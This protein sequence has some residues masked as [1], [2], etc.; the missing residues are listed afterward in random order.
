MRSPNGTPLSVP[1]SLK[2]S[3]Y[4]AVKHD[5]V[6]GKLKPGAHIN[7]LE[8]SNQMHISASPLREALNLL[9][10]DGL[11]EFKPRRGAFVSEINRSDDECIMQLRRMV[12]PLA[13]ELSVP[14]IPLEEILKLRTQLE[15]VLGHLEDLETYVDSDLNVHALIYKYCT[16]PVITDTM[17]LIETHS[18]RSR[19]F[20]ELFEV[21]TEEEKDHLVKAP[22]LEHMDILDAIEKRDITLVKS[23]LEHHIQSGG[24]RLNSFSA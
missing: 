23:L 19:H 15:Y 4:D 9:C 11:V 1:L 5:I 7:I 18:L 3:V 8:M 20:P 21:F 22:T 13:A 17:K 16:S 6:S 2:D 10:R 12:E 14:L 24:K